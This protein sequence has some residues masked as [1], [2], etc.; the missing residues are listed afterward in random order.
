[1]RTFF[2]FLNFQK[3]GQFFFN[4]IKGKLAL[5]LTPYNFILGWL[6]GTF[7]RHKAYQRGLPYL[8]LPSSAF[9]TPKLGARFLRFST[10]V[11][12]C[13]PRRSLPHNCALFFAFLS[14]NFSAPSPVVTTPQLC[15]HF[16]AFLIDQFSDCFF[17]I[18]F[19]S[20]RARMGRCKHAFRVKF[21]VF[22]P[23][24]SKNGSLFSRN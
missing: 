7:R 19:L 6:S 12:A 17:C 22:W 20:T 9:T 16:F 13:L 15:A 10:L 18:F 5:F 11:L 21:R 8:T 23:R 3:M 2:A 4:E 1:M 24:I 14:I